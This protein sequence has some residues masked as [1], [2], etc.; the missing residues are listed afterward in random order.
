[1]S[2]CIFRKIY[3][4]N[5]VKYPIREVAYGLVVLRGGEK[6]PWRRGAAEEPEVKKGSSWS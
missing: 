5:Y 4:L 3:I 1:M 2:Y 6:G